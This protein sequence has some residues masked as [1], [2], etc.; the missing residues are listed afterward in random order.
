M[1]NSVD[2]LAA[3]GETLKEKMT[4]ALLLCSLPESYN[5]LIT[6]LETRSEN[7]LTIELVK[8]KLLDEDR[9]RKNAKDHTDE[10][11]DKA[12]KAQFKKFAKT[13]QKQDVKDVTCFFCQKLGHMKKDC[14]KYKKWKA[15]KEKEK[16]NQAVSENKDIHI[17]FGVKSGNCSG[18]T[19]YIDSGATSHMSND[20]NFFET[21]NTCTNE[22]ITLANGDS[23]EVQGIGD[24]YLTCEDEK[25]KQNAIKVK[26]VLYVPTLEENLLSVRKLTQ[27]GLQVNFTEEMC[28]IMK[29]DITV[30][31]ADPCGNLYRLRFDHKV[32]M[33]VNKH[34]KDCQHTW[35][36]KLGHRDPEAV[37]QMK[38]K[39]LV[40]GL[41]ITD[42]GIRSIC[43]T[44]I[45]GKMTR[46]S[47]PKKSYSNTEEPLH[48]IH[49]D[50]CGPM[51]TVTPGKKR[52]ILTLI[53]DYSKYTVVYLMEHKSEVTEKIQEYI[54]N[55]KTKFKKVPKI[56][57]S[58]QGREYV[59]AS[60]KNF[61]RKEG[62]EMQYTVGYAPEQNGTAERKNRYFM[63]MAR[64]MLIDAN[65]PNK[66]WGEAVCTANYLQN[67]LYTK[68][69]GTTPFERWYK[70]KPSLQHIHVFGSEVYAHVP[71]ELR[72]KLDEKA[73]KFIFVGYAENAKG[74]RLLDMRTDRVIISR[75]VNFLDEDNES[76]EIIIQKKQDEKT[77]SD[78]ESILDPVKEKTTDTKNDRQEEK[79]ATIEEKSSSQE[80]Q[81]LRRSQRQNKGIPPNRYCNLAHYSGGEGMFE[82]DTYEEAI[83]S[84]C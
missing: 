8:G 43:E 84:P 15:E 23:A 34:R 50:V 39:D 78:E 10:R 46:R 59:N 31:T 57:R 53:D 2:Q 14:R 1:L 67:R 51:Q 77:Q 75:D 79:E 16:V 32:L 11:D 9:R 66:Y 13:T 62:I 36:R 4:I 7:E 28:N 82:P 18:R 35:H 48:L 3:L 58:D 55:M 29:D 38:T 19:W 54:N 73:K 26:E 45:K 25:G 22:N 81:Q 68:V 72:R 33:V 76:K 64:C 27:K 63:E 80:D 49:T 37:K 40:S 20:K 21:L 6:A 74:Y 52:Y 24:G 5:T 17:C 47:F 42:C 65:L 56:I 12:L 83:S 60:L 44:C 41:E 71:K 30:A 61:L 69:T 70:K